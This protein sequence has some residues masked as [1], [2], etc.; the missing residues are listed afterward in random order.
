MISR[1]IKLFK[2]LD[3]RIERNSEMPTRIK[4]NSG[5]CPPRTGRKRTSARAGKLGFSSEAQFDQWVR[6]RTWRGRGTA[7]NKALA[8]PAN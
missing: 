3:M 5:L 2:A 1:N 6:R 4:A 7:E 8:H